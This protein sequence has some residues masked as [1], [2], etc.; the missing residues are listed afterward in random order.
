LL[1]SVLREY[2]D[3]ADLLIYDAQYTPEEYS[4]FRGWGHS[5]WAEGVKVARDAGAKQL[6]LFHHDPSHN[7]VFLDDI[8]EV[9]QQS[10]A[11]AAPAREGSTVEFPD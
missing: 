11:C 10:F 9:A 5:T 2:A 8:A 3:G 6:L 4:R 1:D 7:D